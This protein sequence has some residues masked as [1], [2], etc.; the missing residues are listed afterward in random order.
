MIERRN[1]T[2]DEAE[3]PMPESD[4]LQPV[5]QRM[6]AIETRNVSDSLL[7]KWFEEQAFV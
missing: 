1:K 4:A 2:K 7:E 3:Q 6:I 5:N